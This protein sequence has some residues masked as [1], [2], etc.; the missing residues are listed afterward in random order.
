MEKLFQIIFERLPMNGNQDRFQRTGRKLIPI[1]KKQN[2]RSLVNPNSWE[3]K[4]ILKNNS[5]HTEERKVIGTSQHEF[6]KGKSCLMNSIA[7]YGLVDEEH[8]ADTAHLDFS[9]A[10]NISP[11]TC[12]M[13]KC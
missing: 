1:F 3:G 13:T 2:K 6:V 5:K 7:F 9:K 12:S 4:T 11:I 8:R 10:F